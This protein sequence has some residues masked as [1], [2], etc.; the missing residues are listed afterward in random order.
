MAAFVSSS[1]LHRLHHRDWGLV[2]LPP[3]REATAHGRCEARV[4]QVYDQRGN[5]RFIFPWGNC[6]S[7]QKAFC[8]ELGMDALGFEDAWCY[9]VNAGMLACRRIS[10]GHWQPRPALQPRPPRAGF[11]F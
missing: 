1:R 4:G 8:I 7:R 6:D 3:E 10:A 5:L 9:G 11:F 2:P